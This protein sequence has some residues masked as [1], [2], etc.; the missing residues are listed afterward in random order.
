MST[1]D[2]NKIKT[3]TGKKL[4]DMLLKIWD[5]DDFIGGVLGHLKGDEKK[6]KMIKILKEGLTD[7]STIVLLSIDIA[8]GLEV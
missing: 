1:I 6:N 3:N 7:R 2:R 4:F 5:N 8:D